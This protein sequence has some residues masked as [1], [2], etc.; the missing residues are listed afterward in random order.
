MT[1]FVLAVLPSFDMSGPAG[2]LESFVPAVVTLAVLLAGVAVTVGIIWFI[3][4]VF[5]RRRS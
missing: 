2:D 4:D 5:V 1:P 3:V